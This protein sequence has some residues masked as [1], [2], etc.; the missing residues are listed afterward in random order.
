MLQLQCPP[1]TVVKLF[2][3]MICEGEL[4]EPGGQRG[5]ESTERPGWERERGQRQRPKGLC[6]CGSAP[7]QQSN[8]INTLFTLNLGHMT[9]RGSC[10]KIFR[11]VHRGLN[12]RVHWK[13]SG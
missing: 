8:T 11:G 2:F 1:D 3:L 12:H 10:E 13:V 9:P 5:R 4:H 7:R 6:L